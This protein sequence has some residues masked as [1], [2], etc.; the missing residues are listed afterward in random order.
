MKKHLLLVALQWTAYAL[1]Q[2]GLHFHDLLCGDSIFSASEMAKI[3]GGTRD[4]YICR[5]HDG[6]GY[7]MV[8]TDMFYIFASET[9][10]KQ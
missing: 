3:E 10:L 9:N 2:D 6:N 4:A 5:R 1:S 8:T 7:L